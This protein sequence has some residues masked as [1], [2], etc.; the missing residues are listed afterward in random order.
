MALLSR[1]PDIRSRARRHEGTQTVECR[2]LRNTSILVLTCNGMHE[3]GKRRARERW[4][5]YHITSCTKVKESSAGGD[6]PSPLRLA[7]YVCFPRIPTDRRHNMTSTQK[8]RKRRGYALTYRMRWPPPAP[9]A[10]TGCTS[11][12]IRPRSAKPGHVEPGV[13]T[14]KL[15]ARS[16]DRTRGAAMVHA[17][18]EQACRAYIGR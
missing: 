15:C 10:L 14:A 2:L 11:A 17:L 5:E 1:N 12:P 13:G 6:V 8:P 9:L 7:R 18:A 3:S 16:T 4:T